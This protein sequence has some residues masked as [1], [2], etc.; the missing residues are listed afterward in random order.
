[1]F[2]CNL[3]NVI[4]LFG[5]ANYVERVSLRIAE[6]C[7]GLVRFSVRAVGS[8]GSGPVRERE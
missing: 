1:V 5:V 3:L 8:A 6:Y 7:R 4:D 2:I